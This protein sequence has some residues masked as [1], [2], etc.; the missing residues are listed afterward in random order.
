MYDDNLV[1]VWWKWTV[2]D[3]AYMTIILI[4]GFFMILGLWNIKVSRIVSALIAFT[5]IT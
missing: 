2:F 1:L 5:F 3:M 4:D